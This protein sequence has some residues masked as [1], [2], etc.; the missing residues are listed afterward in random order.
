MSVLPASGNLSIK[1]AA[2]LNR[3]IAWEVD[4]NLTGDKSLATPAAA[5]GFSPPYS[6]S[7]FYGYDHGT[8]TQTRCGRGAD[9][10]ASCSDAVGNERTFYI[11]GDQTWTAGTIVYTDAARTTPLTGFAYVTRGDT[12]RN[13]TINSSTG[14]LIADISDCLGL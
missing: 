13:W 8:T 7:D 11:R 2:G 3:S 5:A 9:A 10:A 14:A 6:M 4:N 1:D 12:A